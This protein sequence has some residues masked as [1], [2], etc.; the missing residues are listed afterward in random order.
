VVQYALLASCLLIAYGSFIPCFGRIY[1]AY[2]G[3]FIVLSFW[4]GIDRMWEM[5]W[6]EALRWWESC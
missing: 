6:E 4:M 1:A 5:S 2:G 3:F